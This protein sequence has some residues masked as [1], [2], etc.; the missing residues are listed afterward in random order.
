MAADPVDEAELEA[1]A[2]NA[3]LTRPRPGH[4]DLV[5]MQKYDFDEARPILERA[6]ARETAARVALGAVARPSSSRRSGAEIVSHVVAIGTARA[7]YGSIPEPGDV[8]R[9]RRRPGALPRRRRQQGD[10][11]RDRPGPQG[12]RHPRRCRRGRRVRPAAGPRLARALGPAPRRPPGRRA[13]GHPGDQGRRGRRRLRPRRGPRAPRRTTRSSTP[14]T[15]SG[16]RRAAPA[17]PRAACPP[18]RCCGCAPR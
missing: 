15:A 7:P 18:A 9:A 17:A 5:G 16:V 6:C 13:H 14:P 4:A 10:G 12:R 3:P 11:R 2:R 8:A 1:L